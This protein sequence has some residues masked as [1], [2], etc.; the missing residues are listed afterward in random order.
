MGQP[1]L[2]PGGQQ[3]GMTQPNMFHPGQVNPQQPMIYQPDM[4][5]PSIQHVGIQQRG[6]YDPQFGNYPQPMVRNC[7][8][9]MIRIFF[10]HHRRQPAK[11][12]VKLFTTVDILI[13]LAQIRFKC[14]LVQVIL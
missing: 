12:L 4:V 7:P 13:N 8:I 6:G 2:M 9:G 3:V 11:A 10:R 14:N 1:G 5:V